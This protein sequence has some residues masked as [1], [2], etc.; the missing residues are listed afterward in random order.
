MARY[1]DHPSSASF[2]GT[3]AAWRGAGPRNQSPRSRSA[4]CTDGVSVLCDFLVH[5]A[6]Y[7]VKWDGHSLDPPTEVAV[8]LSPVES[9]PEGV[10]VVG[11]A[12]V[13]EPPDGIHSVSYASVNTRWSL[14]PHSGTHTSPGPSAG[15]RHRRAP[16]RHGLGPARRCGRS[17]IA[18]PPEICAWLA[19]AHRRGPRC[20]TGLATRTRCG[21]LTRRTTG[22]ASVHL[23]AAFG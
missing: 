3:T 17:L 6:G 9:L 23:A 14:L 12:V 19:A 8:G 16:G 13:P 2:T 18:A 11:S 22:T 21:R 15:I 20:P 7:L 4:G 1:A 5:H 10:A